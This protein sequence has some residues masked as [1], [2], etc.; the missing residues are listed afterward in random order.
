M[1]LEKD[2]F[3]TFDSAQIKSLHA[4]GKL[5]ETNGATWVK[6]FDELLNVLK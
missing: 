3:A 6:S 4:V 1:V 5:V 2:D